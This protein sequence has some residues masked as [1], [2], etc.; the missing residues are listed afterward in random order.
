MRFD[1][2]AYQLPGSRARASRKAGS[3]MAETMERLKP[4]TSTMTK[5]LLKER[6]NYIA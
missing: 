5:A 6:R 1:T 4:A 2:A 3:E